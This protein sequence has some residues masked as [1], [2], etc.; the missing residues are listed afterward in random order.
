VADGREHPPSL[1]EPTRWRSVAVGA[2]ERISIRLMDDSTLRFRGK[3]DP[4]KK[5]LSLFELR[6]VP[7]RREPDVNVAV[8]TYSASDPGVIVLEGT[9]RSTPIQIQLRKTERKFLLLERGFHW[10]SE[11]PFNR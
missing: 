7:N 2:R 3:A 4:E 9:F 8:L 11:A 6:D 10:I 1:L 5:T